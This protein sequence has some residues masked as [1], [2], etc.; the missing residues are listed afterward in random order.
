[1]N[2]CGSMKACMNLR[3]P[4]SFFKDIDEKKR[5]AS[6]FSVNTAAKQADN[7]ELF[8]NSSEVLEFLSCHSK[9][10]E[11]ASNLCKNIFRHPAQLDN[12]KTDL[13]IY[14]VLFTD[15]KLYIGANHIL[16]TLKMI[17]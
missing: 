1:M 8:L 15:P 7:E 2:F 9:E 13:D 6:L 12:C 10:Q 11:S 5:K 4:P 3:F 17:L 14:K 16:S